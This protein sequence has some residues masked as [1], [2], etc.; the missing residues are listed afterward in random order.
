MSATLL[1][2]LV[3]L[4]SLAELEGTGLPGDTARQPG[5]RVFRAVPDGAG[6][7]HGEPEGDG[8][9]LPLRSIAVLPE[10]RRRGLG[11]TADRR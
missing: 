10:L 9:D 11:Q 1:L 3:S 5:W 6:A 4:D 7:C 2:P 8:P